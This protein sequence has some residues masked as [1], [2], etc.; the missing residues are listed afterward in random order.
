MFALFSD[1]GGTSLPG[2]YGRLTRPPSFRRRRLA[3]RNGFRG[4][5]ARL[6]SSLSTLRPAGCPNRTQDSFPA[7]GHALPGGI[8]YPQ[9]S[10]ERFQSCFLHLIPLSQA[11]PGA[12]KMPRWRQEPVWKDAELSVPTG[13]QRRVLA[14]VSKPAEMEL[15][16][17][18]HV[19]GHS[20]CTPMAATYPAAA[21]G[22]GAAGTG[23][24]RRPHFRRAAFTEPP[25]PGVRPSWPA[26][27]HVPYDNTHSA[28]PAPLCPRADLRRTS[29]L[30]RKVFDMS[31]FLLQ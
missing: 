20:F 30:H 10:N 5:I 1:P 24:G 27:L 29:D 8:G 9:G 18:K 17:R 3:A 7:A 14:S 11:L 4:S 22:A 25:R 19:P 2:H 21:A 26:A 28:K 23:H 13:R 12:T 16:V 6:S 15:S 31:Y